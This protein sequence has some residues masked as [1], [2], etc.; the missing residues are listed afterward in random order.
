MFIVLRRKTITI[1]S[2]LLVF[3]LSVSG[4]IVSHKISKASEDTIKLPIVMYHHISPKDSLLNRFTIAPSTLEEDLRYLKSQ[5]FTTVSVA[6]VIDFCQKNKP[7]PKKPI[8]LTFDDGFESFYTYAYPLLKQ[9]K[10]KAVLSITGKYVDQFTSSDDHNVDY[11]YLT[12]N[13]VKELSNSPYVEIGNHTYDMHTS[14]AHRLGCRKNRNEDASR[15]KEVLKNDLSTLQREMKEHTGK[16]PIVFAYP[17]GYMCTEAGEVLRDMG[18]SAA[19]T[20]N[21]RINH[22]THDQNCLFRLGRFNRPNGYA[23]QDYFAKI[24]KGYEVS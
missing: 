10:A 11:S 24:L 7:L 17:F 19:F 5:G 21:G 3:C 12:W 15:Y 4:L 9:Y 8:L 20:C 18:F 13:E 23:S 16:E 2:L 22:L 6:E 1:I 14:D